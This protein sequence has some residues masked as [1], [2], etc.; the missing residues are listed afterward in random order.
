MAKTLDLGER[1]ELQ[2]LDNHCQD[3]SLGLYQ[4]RVDGTPRFL[5]HTY[6]SAPGNAERIMFLTESLIQMLGLER[7]EESSLWLQFPC[8]TNHHRALKRS[9]LDLCKLATGDPLEPKPLTVHDKKADG[10]LSAVTVG[11]G[12]YE[13]TSEKGDEAGG[14]RSTALAR[15]FVKICEMGYGDS[16]K[17]QIV[18]PC[19]TSHDA[20][21]G[22]LMFRAQNVRAS[23]QEDAIAASRGILA[24]PSQQK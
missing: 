11:G 21:I 23:M 20:L 18:F 24:A 4:R 22:M 2:P 5:I 15:G 12:V 9:F 7:V 3:I 13:I 8:R 16:E 1:I 6:S 19:G 17:N 10:N 14:K